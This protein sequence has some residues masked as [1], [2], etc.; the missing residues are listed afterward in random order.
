MFPMNSLIFNNNK[1]LWKYR[2]HHIR[3]TFLNS[4]TKILRF[5]QICGP[6]L[7]TKPIHLSYLCIYH[8]LQFSYKRRFWTLH[9]LVMML[10]K[11]RNTTEHESIL[12]IEGKKGQVDQVAYVVIMEKMHKV[13]TW[14][15]YY[16][17]CICS[18]SQNTGVLL[19]RTGQLQETH[20]SEWSLKGVQM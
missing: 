15:K 16:K 11:W 18:A 19:K 7:N 13:H 1:I 14:S 6:L 8:I 10:R 17:T 20:N 12:F 4:V 9:W 2:L 5:S 3:E